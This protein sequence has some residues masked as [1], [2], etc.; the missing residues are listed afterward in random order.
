MVADGLDREH[1][2]RSCIARRTS[3][4]CARHPLVSGWV[5]QRECWMPDAILAVQQRWQFHPAHATFILDVPEEVA[6]ERM[7][8][9]GALNPIYEK[10]DKVR[11]GRMRE[12]YIAYSAM[13]DN[14]AVLNG[15]RTTE[16]LV[17]HVR[18]QLQKWEVVP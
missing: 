12:R 11:A 15:M 4:I 3:V 9:R 14:C 1:E 5:Y 17:E 10:D 16:E 8:K 7:K 18:Q 6:L 13:H 2:I